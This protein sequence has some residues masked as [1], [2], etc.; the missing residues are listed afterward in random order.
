[1]SLAGGGA[2]HRKGERRKKLL[3]KRK[4]DS[5]R[6]YDPYEVTGGI[7][8]ARKDRLRE[9]AKRK[10]FAFSA[11]DILTASQFERGSEELNLPD[12]T[13]MQSLLFFGGFT[14][15]IVGFALFMKRATEK[16]T[17]PVV[18]TNP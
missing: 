2:R 5:G 9:E 3:A 7:M 14:A 8:A 18:A 16:S 11:A 6:L 12:P 17:P 4:R 1:M 10:F 15:V 13:G